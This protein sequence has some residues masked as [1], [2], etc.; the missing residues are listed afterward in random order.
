MAEKLTSFCRK[1]S[2]T[3]NVRRTERVQRKTLNQTKYLQKLHETLNLEKYSQLSPGVRIARSCGSYSPASASTLSE[4]LQL[5]SFLK[6][7]ERK[8]DLSKKKGNQDF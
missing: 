6:I 1:I 2:L 7:K 3:K 4:D 8:N 5:G